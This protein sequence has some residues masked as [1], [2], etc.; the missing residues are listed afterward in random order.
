MEGKTT[1]AG[2][3][4]GAPGGIIKKVVSG[5]PAEMLH[6]EHLENGH[7]SATQ[8]FLPLAERGELKA[9]QASAPAYDGL[10]RSSAVVCAPTS[11]PF[12]GKAHSTR[13]KQTQ[14]ES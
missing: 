8:R 4:R 1:R 7:P 10:D 6:V 11:R 14:P 2:E 3:G 13:S 5:V 12:P 9:R